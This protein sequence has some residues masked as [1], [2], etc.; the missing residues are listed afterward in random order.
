M[1]QEKRKLTRVQLIYYL[2]IFDSNTGTNI[3][4]LV[5]ITTEG[6]MVISEEPVPVNK[7]YT[8]IMHLPKTMS[9]REK[10]QF[11][12]HCLWCRLDIN[13]DFYVSGYRIMEIQP[14]ELMT[15][16]ALINDYG[17]KST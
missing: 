4:H 8:F 11:K 10:I 17:F 15:I 9:G 13:P 14:D 16:K 2:R 7:D 12:A 1:T 5:D 6:I 3:G